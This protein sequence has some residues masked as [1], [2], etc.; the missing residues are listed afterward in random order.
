MGCCCGVVVVVLLLGCCCA[1]FLPLL[2]CCCGCHWVPSSS[3]SAAEAATTS[4]HSSYILHHPFHQIFPLSFHHPFPPLVINF[5]LSPSIFFPSPPSSLPPQ[6]AREA[7]ERGEVSTP[8]EHHRTTNQTSK[9]P[10]TSDLI[11]LFSAI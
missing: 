11:L 5:D 4:T 7:R 6:T 10:P 1:V 2:C 9:Q 3:S 8:Q